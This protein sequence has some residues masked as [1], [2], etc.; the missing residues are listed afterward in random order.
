MFFGF[1]NAQFT[2]VQDLLRAL[3]FPSETQVDAL[4]DLPESI[5]PNSSEYNIPKE[6]EI[7]IETTLESVT[8]R[9]PS[10]SIS[11]TLGASKPS[12]LFALLIGIDEYKHDALNN[13]N[14]SVADAKAVKAFLETSLGVPASQIQTLYNTEATRDAIIDNIR[15]FQKNPSI[16]NGDPI[17]IFY[18][19]HG[20]TG[21]A[22]IDWEAGGPEIQILLSHDTLCED[23]GREIC[24]VPD[25]TM[26]A[27]LDQLSNEKGNN[28]T[29]IFDCCHSGS[30]TR[31]ERSRLVR[32]VNLAINIPSDLDKDIWGGTR[33]TVIEPK[34]LKSGLSSH[35]LLAACGAQETAK[36]NLSGTGGVF[37]TALLD[38]LVSV[39]VEK[40]TYTD[41]IQRLPSLV[42]QT[43]QCEGHNQNRILFDSKVRSQHRRLY[44]LR[45]IKGEY[46]MKAGAAHGI[47]KGATFD[48]YKDRNCMTT[49]APL[50]SLTVLDSPDPFT[51]VLSGSKVNI[52]K[53]A[54][55]LQTGA[56]VEE[57]LII[58]IAMDP[59]LESVF[60]ALAEEIKESNAIQRQIRA[61]DEIGKAHLD[62]ALEDGKIIFNIL[63]PL[64]TDYGL[65][66][67]PYQLNPTVNEV[68]RVL[69][70][71]AHYYWHLHRTGKDNILQEKVKVEFTRLS[72]DF[73]NNDGSLGPVRMPQGPNLIQEGVIDIVVKKGDMYG[74]KIINTSGRSLYPS[75]F[76]FDN[77]NLSITS[78]FQPPTSKGRVDPPLPPH[79]SLA[80]GYGAGGAPPFKYFIPKGQEIDVGF[81]KVF[82]SSRKV[83]LSTV[84]QL[85]PFDN[86]GRGSDSVKGRP[87]GLWSTILIT[88]VQRR[89]ITPVNLDEGARLMGQ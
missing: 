1:S 47:T 33:G 51:T 71:A 73:Q 32:G 30:L 61:V 6:P 27:L 42:E 53:Q 78:Y 64:V 13:L 52:G 19:G 31:G 8:L 49:D 37:T 70:A 48:V 75:V 5:Q 58:H 85:S 81:I 11:L 16:K 35:V 39:G 26:G 22:P 54:V 23:K 77:S 69:R 28:I 45:E 44:V 89:R 59:K 76:Y 84:P 80:I 68:R 15:A 46:V 57:D 34:F 50:V 56:G 4:L 62:I 86:N 74:I 9:K 87:A 82:L 29:V 55:A 83:D 10:I 72:E 36:E 67:M 25:R 7:I 3:I 12:S 66:R 21:N 41:L 65:K 40:L 14:A 38:T 43:P 17:L 2:H 63:N 88:I 18:S 60:R 79:E 20:G 24:G